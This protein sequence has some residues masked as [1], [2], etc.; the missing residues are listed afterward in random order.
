MLVQGTL[1]KR[2]FFCTVDLLFTAFHFEKSKIF[3]WP[4]ASEFMPWKSKPES[5]SA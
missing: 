3:S 4:K 5:F 1:T 2:D